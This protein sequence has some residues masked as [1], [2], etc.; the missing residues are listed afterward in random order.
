MADSIEDN[1]KP[2]GASLFSSI[3]PRSQGFA[4]WVQWKISN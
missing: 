1:A 2:Q 4:F 3:D